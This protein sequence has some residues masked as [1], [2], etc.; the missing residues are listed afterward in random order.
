MI[1]GAAAL[2]RV[3]SRFAWHV[4]RSWD[5]GDR[6]LLTSASMGSGDVERSPSL[7]TA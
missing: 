6:S 3:E 1:F 4:L 5:D 2:S 7:V